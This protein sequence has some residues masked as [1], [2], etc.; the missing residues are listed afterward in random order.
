MRWL[1]VILFFAY[2]YVELAVFIQVAEVVGLFTAILLIVISSLVGLS[3]VR[4]KGFRTLVLVQQK[5][6]DGENPATEMLKSVSLIIAGLLLLVPG[7]ITDILG[8]VLLL[9]PL[10]KYLLLK[11]MPH[12]R[13]SRGTGYQQHQGHT[14]E[15]EY[16]RKDDDNN[17]PGSGS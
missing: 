3:L 8:L 5:I 7:F 13:F 15:G 1:L 17:L 2:I 10:Q 11:F 16:Q 4:N 6:R 14:F 12:M 9:P